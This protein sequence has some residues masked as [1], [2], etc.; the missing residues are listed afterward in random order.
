MATP[1]GLMY[2]AIAPQMLAPTCRRCCQPSQI[3]GH[4]QTRLAC[5]S[6]GGLDSSGESCR[7]RSVGAQQKGNSQHQ[8]CTQSAGEGG[9]VRVV[10]GLR[11][12]KGPIADG[13]LVAVAVEVLGA[14][15]SP[16]FLT[17]GNRG[18]YCWQR[19]MPPKLPEATLG[20]KSR[21]GPPRSQLLC[22]GKA[23]G[24]MPARQAC[25]SSA[26]PAALPVVRRPRRRPCRHRCSW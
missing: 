16:G 2:V 18:E 9:R 24:S 25:L 12:A 23:D 3:E 6:H 8:P 15:A 21:A 14:G 13:A 5:H 1:V 11:V 19:G 10:N 26:S 17:A 20:D 4:C 7:H 22:S